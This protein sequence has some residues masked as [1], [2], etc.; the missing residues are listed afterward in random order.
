MVFS[1]KSAVVEILVFSKIVRSRWRKWSKMEVEKM[2]WFFQVEKMG[3]PEWIIKSNIEDYTFNHCSSKA[4]WGFPTNVVQF[5]MDL[6]NLLGYR[7][8]GSKEIHN[9][10]LYFKG[11]TVNKLVIVGYSSRDNLLGNTYKL[12]YYY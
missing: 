12:E 10:S 6:Q 5:V 8:S 7:K 11:T 1:H 3:S 9:C 2:V 4:P